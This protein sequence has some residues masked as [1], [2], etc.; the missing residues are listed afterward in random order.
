MEEYKQYTHEALRMM[1]SEID[2]KESLHSAHA[3][4]YKTYGTGGFMGDSEKAWPVTE[5]KFSASEM[6][7]ACV[8]KRAQQLRP[9]APR[10]A[11]P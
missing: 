7:V 2:D 1:A 9:D 3:L 10:Q 4:G 5:T 6:R 8:A 11:W